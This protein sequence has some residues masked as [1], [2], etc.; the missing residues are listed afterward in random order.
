MTDVFDRCAME[1]LRL[2]PL[3]QAASLKLKEA[4]IAEQEGGGPVFRLMEWGLSAGVRPT[5]F[6]TAHELMRLGLRN[7]RQAAVDY[8]LTNLPGGATELTRRILRLSPRAA[9]QELL[10]LLDMRLKADPRTTYPAPPVT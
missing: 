9:A 2:T 5:H 1:R 3:N 8:L 6:R 4:G 7:D 10:D